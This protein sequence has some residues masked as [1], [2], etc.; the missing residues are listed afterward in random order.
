MQLDA[1][2]ETVVEIGSDHASKSQEAL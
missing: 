2:P 1:L